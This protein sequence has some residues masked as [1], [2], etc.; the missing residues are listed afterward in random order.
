[1]MKHYIHRN[2]GEIKEYSYEYKYGYNPNYVQEMIYE[3]TG[4]VVERSI[5]KKAI[6]DV[7]K[8]VKIFK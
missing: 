7:R 3:E 2:W 6:K 8:R 5:I 4:V 1:M